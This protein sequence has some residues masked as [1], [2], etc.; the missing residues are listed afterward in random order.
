M[1]RGGPRLRT[2]NGDMNGI[3]LRVRS[4][5]HELRLEQDDL[6]AR[7]ARVTDGM[8]NPAWQDIS[9]VENGSRTTTDLEVVA[10][11]KALECSPCWLLT[12]T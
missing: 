2:A 8:W 6:C 12:G 11:A 4:R 9:R 5:R 10:F 3:G 7:I 1:P